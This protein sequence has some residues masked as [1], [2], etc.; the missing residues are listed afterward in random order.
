MCLATASAGAAEP[1]TAFES[2]HV[3]PLAL[4]ADGSRLYAVNTPDNRLTVYRTTD[5]GLSL[6]AEIPVGLEPVAVA[7]RE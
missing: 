4:S 7:L 1:F 5:A 3:R 2:A 6:E